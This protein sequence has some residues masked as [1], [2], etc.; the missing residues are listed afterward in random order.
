MS[1]VL[2]SWGKEKPNL[3]LVGLMLAEA[4]TF[5]VISS[6][7]EFVFGHRWPNEDGTAAEYDP[8]CWHI[9]DNGC[10]AGPDSRGF[11]CCTTMLEGI[12][13]G[14]HLGSSRS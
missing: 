2:H 4:K 11:E 5:H 6:Q 8:K 9:R 14:W 12:S 3:K 7:V 1:K 10:N 13:K